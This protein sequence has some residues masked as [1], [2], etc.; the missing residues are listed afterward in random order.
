MNFSKCDQNKIDIS[1]FGTHNL[2]IPTSYHFHN[3]F[4]KLRNCIHGSKV[5]EE[6]REGFGK[7][8]SGVMGKK[9]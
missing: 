7:R 5:G 3:F 6:F 8:A 2:Q 9:I 4:Y 1:E